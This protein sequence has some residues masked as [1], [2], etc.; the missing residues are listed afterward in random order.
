MFGILGKGDLIGSDLPGT[1]QVIKTNADVKALTYC[2]LQ[3]ISVRG[4]R[5]VLELYPEY[6]SVFTTDIHNNLTYNLREG[7]QDK[8]LMHSEHEKGGCSLFN[9]T[10]YLPLILLS[11]S[12]CS[13]YLYLT[14][15]T[16]QL[17]PKFHQP[18]HM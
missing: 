1:D 3:Y 8:V 6:A 14:H 13:I 5:E 12:K 2:D 10:C 16:Q 15:A 18:T 17:Q 11:E 9:Q 4:L 7:S